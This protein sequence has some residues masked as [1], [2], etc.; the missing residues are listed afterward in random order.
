[1]S[2]N[3]LQQHYKEKVVP[4]LTKK[5]GYA[6]P[7]QVPRLEKIVVTSCMGKAAD[8]TVAVDHLLEEGCRE[9]QAP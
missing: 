7:H 1:M 8:R 3:A 4:S 6:N 9:L 5:L 2:T